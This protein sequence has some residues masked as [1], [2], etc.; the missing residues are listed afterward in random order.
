[1]NIIKNIAL[2]FWAI[3]LFTSVSTSAY[4]TE[5]TNSTAPIITET[6]KHIE[7]ALIEINKSDFSTAQLFLKSARLSAAKITDNENLVKQANDFV[8]QGQ[9]QTKY[10]DINKS[11]D[12]LNKAL[13]LYKSL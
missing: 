12:E 8:I 5:S 6:I 13:K 3:T 2:I 7:D 11:S 1:M 10:G 9:I 4:S